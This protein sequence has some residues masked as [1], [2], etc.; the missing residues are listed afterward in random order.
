MTDNTF[1]RNS[2]DLARASY[3]PLNEAE[4][5]VE[6]LGYTLDRQL[7]RDDTMV[8]VDARGQP[9]IIHR[10]SVTPRDWLV[11]DV[12]IA[13]GSNH[14]TQRLRRARQITLVAEAKYKSKSNAVGHSL[15]GRLA[16]QAAQAR[17]SHLTVLRAWATS[18]LEGINRD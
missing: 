8:V 1:K 18:A 5:F 6:G 2:V 3:L 12:L 13:A 15:G 11:D 4:K 9:T 17:L 10:G 7:S 16:E 14:E